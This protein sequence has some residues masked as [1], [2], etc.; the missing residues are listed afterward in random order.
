MD[1]VQHFQLQK[2]CLESAMSEGKIWSLLTNPNASFQK[3]LFQ[4]GRKAKLI[5][6]VHK[7]M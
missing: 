1:N 7:E 6:K 3:F 5:S 4:K 2:T